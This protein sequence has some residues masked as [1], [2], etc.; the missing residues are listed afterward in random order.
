MGN[1]K[2]RV[3][4]YT[5][6]NGKRF[7]SDCDMCTWMGIA[8]SET[9][10]EIREIVSLTPHYKAQYMHHDAQP[11]PDFAISIRKIQ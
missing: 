3:E 8:T 2:T 10:G 7:S 9:D 5:D 1:R 6:E 4:Y 11:V